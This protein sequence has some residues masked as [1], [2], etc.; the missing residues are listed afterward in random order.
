MRIIFK[1]F[2]THNKYLSICV[3]LFQ[4]KRNF[5]ISL[6]FVSEDLNKEMNEKKAVQQ[7]LFTDLAYKSYVVR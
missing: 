5:E 2:Y 7:L 3:D 4:E 1:H 6:S